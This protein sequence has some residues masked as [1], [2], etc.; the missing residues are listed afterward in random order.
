MS[1]V[2]LVLALD[3]IDG[4]KKIMP[5]VKTEYVDRVIIVDGGSTDGTVKKAK[6]LGFE[7]IHQKNKGEGNACRVGTDATESEFEMFFR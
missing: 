7:T 3:E 4:M 6:E 5:K 2:L 1:V